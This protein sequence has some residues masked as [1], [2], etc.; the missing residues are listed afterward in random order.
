ML[1]YFFYQ[2]LQR[3]IYG[4]KIDNRLITYQKI[5][6]VMRYAVC[7]HCDAIP[8][9]IH[10]VF[11][12]ASPYKFV[13]SWP[14]KPVDTIHIRIIYRGGCIPEPFFHPGPQRTMSKSPLTN[15]RPGHKDFS[16][17]LSRTP[18]FLGPII[19][20]SIVCGRPFVAKWSRH[21]GR[22]RVCV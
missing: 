22:K 11:L 15:V 1:I 5:A 20:S 4:K 10:P 14:P 7:H 8:S 21:N 19:P 3:L 2:F 9:A 12:I 16:A 13:T 17:D 18:P 6:I